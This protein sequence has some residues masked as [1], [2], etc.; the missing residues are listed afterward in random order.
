MGGIFMKLVSF[1]GTGKYEQIIYRYQ[2]KKSTTT[3]FVQL[4]LSE[5]LDISEVILFVTEESKAANLSSLQAELSVPLK[6]VELKNDYFEELFLKLNQAIQPKDTLTIDVTHAFRSFPVAALPMVNY[7]KLVKDVDV[8]GIFYGKVIG[9]ENNKSG[10]IVDLSYIL[11][12]QRW[13]LAA[14]AFLTYGKVDQLVNLLKEIVKKGFTDGGEIK[15]K[16]ISR[17]SRALESMN[18]H[19]ALNRLKEIA[20]EAEKVQEMLNSDMLID[21]T[22]ARAQLLLPLIDKLMEDISVFHATDSAPDSQM[23]IAKWYLEHNDP[24]SAALIAREAF[25]TQVMIHNN[26][27]NSIYDNKVRTVVSS[28]LHKLNHDN[29]L[30]AID[31]RLREIRNSIAHCS[32]RED[33]VNGVTVRRMLKKIMDEI[34]T[35]NLASTWQVKSFEVNKTTIE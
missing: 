17:L 34:E 16:N 29:P 22:K 5:F 4:A 2:D 31:S 3:P 32:M 1:L 24:A 23:K 18:E 15:P 6:T 7:L 9:Y 20:E 28:E 10:E 25:I 27:E 26:L 19:V 8:L 30:A 11:D 14:Q 35:L 33:N 13:T 12:I 21:E